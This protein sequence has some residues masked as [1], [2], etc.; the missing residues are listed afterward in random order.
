MQIS[1]AQKGLAAAVKAGRVA[2]TDAARYRG[3]LARTAHALPRLSGSRQQNLR[4]VLD[5][6]ANK[7]DEYTAPRALT[8]FSMLDVNTRYFGAKGPPAWHADILGPD[9]VVYRYFPGHGLQFHPLADFGALNAHLAA[10]RLDEARRLT[11]ALQARAIGRDDGSTVWE[12]E[13]RY[14]GGRAPWTSGMA[15]AVAAQS[16]ARASEKLDDPSLLDLARRAEASIPGKL[17]RKLAAGPWV[18]LYSFNTMAV[19]NAQ[20]QTAI[21]IRDYAGIAGDEDAGALADAMTQA[22]E[23]MLPKFDTGYW[24]RYSLGGAEETRDY[25]DYVI[26]LLGRLK[27]QTQSSFWS[28][29]AARFKAY[30]TQ[31]PLFETGPPAAV[32]APAKKGKAA[33][34][35]SF[36]LSKRSSVVV[37]VGSGSRSLSMTGGWHTLTWLLPRAEPGV[38][39]VSVQARPVAGPTATTPLLPLVVL[40]KA[41]A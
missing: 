26:F 34:T 41:A 12:Y 15:Q 23:T 10:N 24:T 16:L 35:F 40:G 20:L 29:A 38:F 7:A 2:P 36:W 39:P 3:I 21:A 4:A 8:L 28:E 30:D 9:M 25:H 14:L 32:A 11:A 37:R 13:F 5:D 6:V 19:L 22:A 27:T 33:F 31:A 18:R 1:V 17:T